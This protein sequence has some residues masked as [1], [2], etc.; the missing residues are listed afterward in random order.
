MCDSHLMGGMIISLKTFLGNVRKTLL[1]YFHGF[2]LCELSYTQMKCR[3]KRTDYFCE[4]AGLNYASDCH[5][6]DWT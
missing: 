5:A 4:E 2:L 6:F 1:V 3:Q